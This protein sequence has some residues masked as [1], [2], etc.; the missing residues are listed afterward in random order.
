MNT[1]VELIQLG[2]N[3]KTCRRRIAALFVTSEHKSY[4]RVS[5]L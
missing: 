4:D 1:G 2:G 5:C 3:D